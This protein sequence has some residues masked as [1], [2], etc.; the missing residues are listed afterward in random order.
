MNQS[1]ASKHT[2]RQLVKL[3]NGDTR[4]AAQLVFAIRRQFP[5]QTDQICF[6][7]AILAVEQNNFPTF[8][9][10]ESVNCTRKYIRHRNTLGYIE[11]TGSTDASF[12]I[13]PGLANPNGLSFESCNYP[14]RFLRHQNFRLVL[15]Q[16]NDSDLFLAD[17]TFY[18]SRCY[19]E[20][21]CFESHN[22]H[23][24]YIRHRNYELWLDESDGSELFQ[25]DASFY[26]RFCL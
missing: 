3:F 11:P 17:S 13:R 19:V 2:M 15:S 4:A 21:A 24:R 23:G 9:R 12:R 6:E 20:G 7:N 14:G 5:H 10:F 8:I 26:F 16:N 25:K 22:Y 1:L 18:R